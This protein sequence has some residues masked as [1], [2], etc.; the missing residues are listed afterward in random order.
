MTERTLRA[1]F[2]HPD[3]EEYSVL[4]KPPT[5]IPED[6]RPKRSG[7]IEAA[8]CIGQEERQY[9]VSFVRLAVVNEDPDSELEAAHEFRK[10]RPVTDVRTSIERR[11]AELFEP[12]DEAYD[13]AEEIARR[14]AS[15][16]L[17]SIQHS[18]IKGMGTPEQEQAFLLSTVIA[19]ELRGLKANMLRNAEHEGEAVMAKQMRELREQFMAPD[20]LSALIRE[21]ASKLD[22][23]GMTGE[24]NIL[25]DAATVIDE[26]F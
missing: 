19:V 26:E 8:H 12:W 10:S 25:R 22:G 13:W 4:F 6:Q 17:D 3:G 14:I 16:T 1:Y 2:V 23:R 5:W 21:G 24:A 11:I 7:M 9:G 15:M 20:F 18:W